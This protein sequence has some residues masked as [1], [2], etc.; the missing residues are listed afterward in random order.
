MFFCLDVLCSPHSLALEPKC[1]VR[2][3]GNSCENLH[4]QATCKLEHTYTYIHIRHLLTRTIF[5]QSLGSRPCETMLSFT[6]R[7]CAR[8]EENVRI[9]KSFCWCLESLLSPDC[10][11]HIDKPCVCLEA[12]IPSSDLAHLFQ[13][14][15][16]EARS[17][18]EMPKPSS[19]AR[20]WRTVAGNCF[21][22][23]TSARW[24]TASLEVPE[25]DDVGTA[26][27]D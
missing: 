14:D 8:V 24:G 5:A 19:R 3:V 16:W 18:S 11:I 1:A 10:E 27:L 22:S 13:N 25:P 6:K 21:S 9:S 17:N 12:F 7:L 4:T 2:H 15:R 23:P 20:G 26:L